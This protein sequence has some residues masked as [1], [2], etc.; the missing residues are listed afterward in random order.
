MLNIRI[1][2]LSTFDS[3]SYNHINSMIPNICYPFI[4]L[5]QL[6]LMQNLEQVA[7]EEASD[8]TRVLKVKLLHFC[9]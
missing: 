1:F 4:K 3:E 9:S 8:T 7:T 6:Q 5:L 2:K